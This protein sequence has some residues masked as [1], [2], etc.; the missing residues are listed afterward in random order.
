VT[1]PPIR[2]PGIAISGELGRSARGIDYRASCGDRPCLLRLSP[3]LAGGDAEPLVRA[4]RTEAIALARARHS[5]IPAVLEMGS[6][7]QRPYVVIELPE[8]ETLAERLRWGRLSESV[9]VPIALRV[10]GGLLDVHR[11][12]LVHG[13]LTTSN[14]VFVGGGDDVRILGFGS[15]PEARDGG[16]PDYRG[17]LSALG[18]LIYE[19]ATGRVAYA[20]LAQDRRGSLHELP[21][22][23]GGDVPLTSPELSRIVL[24]LVRFGSDPADDPA[25]LLS[26]L[27]RLDAGAPPRSVRT[28]S[29]TSGAARLP[30][31]L[32]LIGRDDQLETLRDAWN[33]VRTGAGTLAHVRGAPGSGKTRLVHAFLGQVGAQAR[34][35]LKARCVAGDARPFAAL[36]QLLNDPVRAVI[37]APVADSS[38]LTSAIRDAAQDLA[39]LVKGVS[40]EL[41]RLFGGAAELGA[42]HEVQALFAEG[43]AEF[44]S[45]LL[46]SSGPAIVMIDD[47]QWMDPSSRAVLTRVAD[48][49]RSSKVLFL[50]TS[51]SGD[52]DGGEAESFF[53]P[54]RNLR[55]V[56]CRLAPFEPDQC[57]ALVEAYLGTPGLPAEVIGPLVALGDGTPM[58]LLELLHAITGEGLLTPFWGNWRLDRHGLE[59]MQFP[60]RTREILTRR[61][62]ELSEPTRLALRA[63]AAIGLTFDEGL[64]GD[65]VGANEAG[66]ALREARDARVLVRTAVQSSH[67]IH[68]T[69]REA[70]L[71]PMTPGE[72]RAV[73]QRIAERLDVSENADLTAL[74]RLA[75]AYAAGEWERS[76]DRV[77]RT[78]YEAGLRTFSAF[79]DDRALAFLEVAERAAAAAKIDPEAQFYQALGELY[80][81]RGALSKSRGYFQLALAR[82]ET[83]LARGVLHSRLAWVDYTMGESERA[84]AALETA[85]ASLSDEMPK[86]SASSLAK[87]ALSWRTVRRELPLGPRRMELAESERLRLEA[88]C[89]M[90]YQA[91][92]LAIETDQAAR[93]L[94][95]VLRSMEQ[96]ELLGPSRALVRS[97]LLYGFAQV[98]LGFKGPGWSRLAKAEAMA[99]AIRDPVVSAYCLQIRSVASAW[100]GDLDASLEGGARLL[101]EKGHWLELSE[102]CILCWNQSLIL[103]VRGQAQAAWEWIA[104]ALD[105]VRHELHPTEIRAFLEPAAR[106]ALLT[107]GREGELAQHI[108]VRSCAAEVQG[109]YHRFAIG[110]IARAFTETGD[111]GPAFEAYVAKVRSTVKDPAKAHLG[112]ADFYVHVA[113]ARVH[114]VLRAGE[115]E[116]E[117]RIQELSESV[118]ELRATARIPALA[119]HHLVTEGFLALFQGSPTRA[120]WYFA[121]ADELAQRENCPWVLF[122]VARGRAHLHL[123]EKRFESAQEQAAIAASIAT[124]QG[125]AFRLRWIREEL[126]PS[127]V[128][129]ERIRHADSASASRQL[130][131][132]LQISR[133]SPNDLD[134]VE[135]GRRIID[136]LLQCFRADRGALF[137]APETGGVPVPVASRDASRSDVPA[138]SDDPEDIVLRAFQGGRS[139]VE[140]LGPGEAHA[141]AAA[142]RSIAAAPLVLR[143]RVIG[144]VSLETADHELSPD[145]LRVLETLADQAAVT[146][147]LTRALRARAEELRERK[148]LEDEL[149]QAQ[150]M[151]AIGRLAGAIAHDFNNLLAIIG[152]TL[153]F[154]QRERGDVLTREL[155]DIREACERGAA[156]TRQLLTFTRRQ[157][158]APKPVRLNEA[159]A[160]CIPMIRRLLP[161]TIE[162][163]TR[164]HAESDTISA[165]T[166]RLEQVLLNLTANARDAM[167]NGGCL[168]IATGDTRAVLG[169]AADDK[170]IDCVVLSVADTGQGMAPEVLRQ[171]FEPFFTTKM[172]GTGLGLATVYGIVRQMRGRITVDSIPGEGTVFHM[173]FPTAARYRESEPQSGPRAPSVEPG[174]G[175]ASQVTRRQVTILLVDDERLILTALERGLIGEGFRVIGALTGQEALELVRRGSP[176]IDLVITDVLMPGM[177][178]PELL[179][180]LEELGVRAPHVF[181]SGFTDGAIVPEDLRGGDE[182]LLKPFTI[183]VLTERIR[184]V[185]GEPAD[186]ARLG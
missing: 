133:A 47:L 149:R 103:G 97:M 74:C 48:R 30:E 90:H 137:L 54:I 156:L 105:K 116:R 35:L 132:L 152:A 120:G 130:D 8:G 163:L 85:F 176:R 99:E 52:S 100:A 28:P 125:Y 129:G 88:L 84:W 154:A 39:P 29:P 20:G 142:A 161:G 83:A 36:G 153:D 178:G 139:F 15:A 145:D 123:A 69:V 159:I 23:S 146:L 128:S 147:E 169:E 110:V 75:A 57:R 68:E 112:L 10:L 168:T 109:P 121:R 12:G 157:A 86:A 117:R 4:F 43:A 81:R 18:R 24:R 107:L 25:E 104:R 16:P 113:H 60:T 49:A 38:R 175:A 55:H 51:R 46:Q 166:T 177:S 127:R 6:V 41:A 180:R 37:S 119:A 135:Q 11:R 173:Y 77:F 91:M 27:E 124:K 26:D 186:A 14:V 13:S 101:T 151:E 40:P 98:L 181:I 72:L 5:A 1:G 50:V 140:H 155:A 136:E 183:D 171:V 141:A 106:A 111:L 34:L 31:E 56:E 44:L 131:A 70:L 170:L 94:A 164:F 73:N 79:D 64:L 82:T 17:D 143:D 53:R 184:K 93:F 32:P 65:V 3:A 89:A 22:L 182:L 21:E 2:I 96:A 19:C 58:S 80:L 158:H 115:E 9:V 172:Q 185:L 138:P 144:V 7:D 71:A 78:N 118:A 150:K 66:A 165:D 162:V 122:S 179:E 95:H 174:A 61:L 148:V 102:Y 167:P 67:F 114:Q 108:G 63:A 92:R 59:R 87:L 134:L 33:D 62:A 42:A 126:P 76:A 45:R 160:S